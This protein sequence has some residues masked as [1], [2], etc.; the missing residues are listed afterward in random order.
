M[1][2]LISYVGIG[3]LLLI[4]LVLWVQRSGRSVAGA[5]ELPEAR[6]ALTSLQLNLPPRELVERIFAVQDWDFVSS[7]TLPPIRRVFLQGRRAV[8]LSWLART[9]KQAAR[10]MNFHVRAVRRN[11]NL[12]P[13][14]EIRLAINYLLFLL[15]C[16]VLLGFIWVGGPFRA[17]RMVGYTLGAAEQLWLISGQLLARV[18]PARLG[19][20]KTDWSQRSGAV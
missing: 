9:R 18:D 19:K 7:Q 20:I 14:V 10:L 6:E 5:P 1:S 13:A 16:Q 8:A 4:L 11:A 15:V 17:R 3:L 2:A 12:S